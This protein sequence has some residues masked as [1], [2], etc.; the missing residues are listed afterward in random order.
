M[1]SRDYSAVSAHLFNFEVSWCITCFDNVLCVQQVYHNI[2]GGEELSSP[3]RTLARVSPRAVRRTRAPIVRGLVAA[4]PAPLF[5]WSDSLL[6][7][8]KRTISFKDARPFRRV[9]WRGTRVDKEPPRRRAPFT[10][11]GEIRDMGHGLRGAE[12]EVAYALL[13]ILGPICVF[14]SNVAAPDQLYSGRLVACRHATCSS[15]NPPGAGS[16]I[17]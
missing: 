1:L 15:P 2:L 13:A 12:D 10:A 6:L 14:A 8:G 7:C 17:V 5:T 4:D 3:S 16:F 11:S 9:I